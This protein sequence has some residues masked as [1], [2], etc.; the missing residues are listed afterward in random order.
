MHAQVSSIQNKYNNIADVEML[1]Q[2][3]FV[4]RDQNTLKVKEEFMALFYKE[5]LKQAIK[6]PNFSGTDGNNS[7]SS[8][9]TSDILLDKLAVELTK[10]QAFSADNLFPAV[11]E[12][13]IPI[14]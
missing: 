11:A 4:V 5:L 14:E 12:R 13:Q 6:P 2:A 3:G 7:I 10:N 8:M 9:Y 1:R